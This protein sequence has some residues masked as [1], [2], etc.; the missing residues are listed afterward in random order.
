M[1]KGLFIIASLAI[2]SCGNNE[3]K[4]DL[5]ETAKDI[6]F[7]FSAYSSNATKADSHDK[8]DFFYKTFNVYGWKSFD[9]GS[10][11]ETTNPLFNNVTNEYFASDDVYGS[12]IY[13]ESNGILPKAEWNTI[14][15]TTPFPGWYYQNIRYLDKYAT[16]YQFSAYTPIT[17]TSEVT[18]TPDGTIL[19]GDDANKVTVDATNL[20]ATPA[21]ELAYTGFAK[22][23][24]TATSTVK[25][26]AVNLIFSHELAKFNIK[27]VLNNSVTTPQTVTVKEVSIKHINGT[28]YYDSSKETAE[29][30]KSAWKT[31]ITEASYSVNGVGTET[32]GYQL[33]GDLDENDDN[34]DNYSGYFVMERLMIPQ[35]VQKNTTKSDQLDD[36]T[37]ACVYVEYTIGDQTYKGHYALANLFLQNTDTATSYDFLGGNEYTLTINVGPLPIYFTTEVNVW[38]NHDA[39]DLNA[40]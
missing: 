26:S 17:A 10:T 35:T 31:P 13:L 19:I 40:N 22:D 34:F 20:M 32:A 6:P 2:I 11:W 25:T 8:L 3:L 9:N 1:K 16:N 39:N 18:C 12:V 33:N 7:T 15:G 29:G 21:T 24:M 27:L 30:Y 36:M 37:Q 28:S 14:Q 5:A 4:T 23:Y 38:I